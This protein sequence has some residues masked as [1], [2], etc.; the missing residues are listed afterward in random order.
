MSLQDELETEMRRSTQCRICQHLSGLPE[1]ERHEWEVQ[2]ARP[3]V[4]LSSAAIVRVLGK[5]GLEVSE[6][7]VRAHRKN[8]RGTV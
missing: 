7:S 3:A 4:S 5:H 8:H 2:M 1:G 6:D